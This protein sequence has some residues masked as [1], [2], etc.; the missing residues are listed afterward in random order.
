MIGIEQFTFIAKHLTPLASRP[1]SKSVM[2]RNEGVQF[3]SHLW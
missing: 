2:G 1:N 3:Q